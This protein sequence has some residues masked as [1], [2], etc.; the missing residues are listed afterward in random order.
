L[1]YGKK[2]QIALIE[3]I[4]S[5]IILFISLGIF[6]PG[7]SYHDRWSESLVLLKGKD[8]I[9]T[10]DRLGKDNL[11]NLSF[12]LTALEDFLNQTIPIS[13]TSIISWSETEGTFK[14]TISVAC[15]CTE[16]QISALRSWFT[17][18]GEPFIRVNNRKIKIE[19]WDTT[20]DSIIPGTDVLLIWYNESL[21]NYE[22]SLQNY[23]NDGNGIV[24]MKD[25]RVSSDIDAV[26][27]KIFGLRWISKKPGKDVEFLL[28]RKKPDNSTDIIYNPYK[29]FYH[30]PFPLKTIPSTDD[31]TGC[32]P[33]PPPPTGKFSFNNTDYKFY[34]CW[35][36]TSVYFNDTEEIV[37]VGQ[38]FTLDEYNFSLNYVDNNE[39]IGIS[40]RPEYNFISLL[41]TKK[42]ESEP[43]GVAWGVYFYSTVYPGD[44]N[45]NRILIKANENYKGNLEMP[46]VVLN[47][48]HGN[49]VAWIADFTS[50]ITDWEVVQDD[51]KSLLLSLLLW[52]SNKGAVGAPDIKLG[53]TASY[54]N[55]VNIDM[56]EV[57][58]FNL[59]LGYPY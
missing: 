51:Y 8:L 30:M 4:T 55:T 15:N 2:G 19:F 13:K 23:I 49:R 37:Q 58:R 59:G 26:Q 36:G 27:K 39:T 41:R 25:F 7:F 40:F 16:E 22:Q 53:Y 44:D 6:F 35:P 46:A 43:P 3:M 33:N 28:F 57:Y 56:F 20:L 17:R 52:A 24:E 47:S 21:A 45:P 9:L 34:I 10:I 5:V 14:P 42:G 50:N 32:Q 1:S 12:N 54:I 31:V 11:Y 29:Y 48:S 38:Q 18:Y